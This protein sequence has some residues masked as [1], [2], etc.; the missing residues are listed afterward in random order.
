MSCQRCNS[1][2]IATIGGKTSDTCSV[3]I[4]SP[5]NDRIRFN[6]YVPC[7]MN[8]GCGDYLDFKLCLDCGQVQ[9]MFPL[10]ETKYE[11]EAAED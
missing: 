5:T 2:R 9:G 4:T 6:D 10:P 1:N 8:I 11:R 3:T 7:D